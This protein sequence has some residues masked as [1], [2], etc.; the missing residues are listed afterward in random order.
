MSLH[1]SFF[2]KFKD[3]FFKKLGAKFKQKRKE[4]SLKSQ[5]FYFINFLKGVNVWYEFA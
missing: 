4:N 3:E 2:K 1:A 5:N